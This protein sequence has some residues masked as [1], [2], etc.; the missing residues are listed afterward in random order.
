MV[1]RK[2]ECLH[3]SLHIERTGGTTVD[4]ILQRLYSPRHVFHYDP[5]NEVFICSKHVREFAASNALTEH[6]KTIALK[7][8][9][10]MPIINVFFLRVLKEKARRYGVSPDNFPDDCQ[11]VHG[12]FCAD[13]FKDFSSKSMTVLLRSPFE[14]MISQ[15]NRW[16]VTRGTSPWRK[17]IPFEPTVTFEEYALYETHLNWQSQAVGAFT[18]DDFAVVGTTEHMNDFIHQVVLMVKS[19]KTKNNAS[20][21]FDMRLNAAD[22]SLDT[23]TYERF[24]TEFQKAHAQDC[25]LY[26]Q[27]SSIARDRISSF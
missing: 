19:N 25:D 13:M 10:V 26:N 9:A 3:V 4:K 12:H 17:R 2:T 5:I 8:P 6:L 24:R 11:V 7:H 20:A 15:Y 1:E 14:R 23:S 22:T 27:A 21:S 16:L 18:L